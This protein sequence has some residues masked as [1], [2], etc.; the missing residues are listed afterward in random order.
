MAPPPPLSFRGIARK[1]RRHS[2]AMQSIE[3]SGA[4]LRTENLELMCVQNNFEIPGSRPAA[5]P[6][7]DE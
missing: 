6:R 2:G 7:N 1:V 5:S 4:Q 3:P